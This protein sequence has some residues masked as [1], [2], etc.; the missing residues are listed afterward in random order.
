MFL[1]TYF[2]DASAQSANLLDSSENQTSQDFLIDYN[3]T[4]RI[5]CPSP[6]C[7][8]NIRYDSGT[9]EL[10]F[11]DRA[12]P[13]DVVVMHHLTEEQEKVPASWIVPIEFA[14]FDG[15][16]SCHIST[17][18]CETSS[19]IVTKNGISHSATW[20]HLSESIVDNLNNIDTL[21]QA[22]GRSNQTN[23]QILMPIRID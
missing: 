17:I 15:S 14:D 5:S 18:Y 12:S 3:Y 21:L 1:N 19:I 23:A 4:N 10:S 22:I 13:K 20:S 6:G 9:N 16:G 7:D 2:G 11:I 8:I